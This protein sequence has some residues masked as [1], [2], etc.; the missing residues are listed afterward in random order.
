MSGSLVV[1]LLL[2]PSHICLV[3]S[4]IRQIIVS[5]CVYLRAGNWILTLALYHSFFSSCVCVQFL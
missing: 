3:L 2:L 1:K 5:H 4:D